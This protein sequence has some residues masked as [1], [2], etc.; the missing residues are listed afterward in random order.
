MYAA[1]TKEVKCLHLMHSRADQ[2][3]HRH[4]YHLEHHPNPA[5]GRKVM[6]LPGNY[7][8]TSL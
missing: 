4:P 8:K 3:L 6:S 1:D 7:L 2:A 5:G